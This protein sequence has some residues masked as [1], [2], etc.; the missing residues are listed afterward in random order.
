VGVV[1]RT[2]L[3]QPNREG[4]SD[5]LVPDTGSGREIGWCAGHRDCTVEIDGVQE[6]LNRRDFAGTEE[7]LR[8]ASDGPAAVGE[9]LK[10]VHTGSAGAE[11]G[12]V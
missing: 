6:R 3:G 8:L 10:Q 4:R 12:A 1:N 9:R 2:V 5:S 7:N 11:I